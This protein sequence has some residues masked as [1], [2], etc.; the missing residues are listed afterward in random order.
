MTATNKT[1]SFVDNKLETTGLALLG[2]VNASSGIGTFK[3]INGLM[4]TPSQPNITGV[5]TINSGT[6]RGDV[7]LTDK[8]G[9][10]LNTYVKGDIIYYDTILN[11]KNYLLVIQIMY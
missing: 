1:I 4:M 8:G 2:N 7:I 11:S 10:G 3:E 6:W 5:G 9:T